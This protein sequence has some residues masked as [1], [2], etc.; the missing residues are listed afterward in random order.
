MQ[1]IAI[2]LADV[3]QIVAIISIVTVW[4]VTAS[5]LKSP[6]IPSSNFSRVAVVGL[7]FLYFWNRFVAEINLLG[8][9]IYVWYGLILILGIIAHWTRISRSQPTKGTESQ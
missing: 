3:I 5:R 7:V 1:S 8:E 9:P 2:P 4:L 6:W